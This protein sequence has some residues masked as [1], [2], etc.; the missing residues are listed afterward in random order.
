MF[1]V[2]STAQ[3]HYHEKQTKQRNTWIQSK[4][5]EVLSDTLLSTTIT[6]S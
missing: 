5:E 3:Q 4:V 1:P 6:W 2:P